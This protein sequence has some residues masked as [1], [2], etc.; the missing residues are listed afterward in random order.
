MPDNPAADPPA[1]GSSRKVLEWLPALT[2]AIT[3]LG[4]ISTVGGL[5]SKVQENDRRLGEIE[6]QLHE[7]DAGKQQVIERLARIE[8]KLDA[9]TE[10]G[11]RH[12][13]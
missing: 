12:N 8:G 1:N 4:A 10:A 13:R 3:L 9:S 6:R 2:A 7:G 11:A 5:I